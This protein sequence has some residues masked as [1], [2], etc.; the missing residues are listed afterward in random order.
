VRPG[1]TPKTYT[2]SPPEETPHFPN[3][4]WRRTDADDKGNKGT[5]GEGEAPRETDSGNTEPEETQTAAA[6]ATTNKQRTTPDNRTPNT[7]K[8][9]KP[10]QGEEHIEV[11]EVCC[12]T[13]RLSRAFLDRGSVAV[14][15]D[16]AT[17]RH[18]TEGPTV[19]A[20]RTTQEGTGLVQ[21]LIEHSPNLQLVWCGLP[22]GTCSRAR[23]IPRPGLPLPL[24]S[25]AE[26]RGVT[27]RTLTQEKQCKFDAANAVYDNAGF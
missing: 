10:R 2:K 18:D 27:S 15:V 22:C 13:A 9:E 16:Q 12:D 23:E 11:L 21:W 3:L 24:R 4:Q 25:N 1:H 8:T 6:T 17:N 7:T 20:D 5:E 19:T 26:P 14:G